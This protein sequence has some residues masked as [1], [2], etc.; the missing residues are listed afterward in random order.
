VYESQKETI[1]LYK[2]KLKGLLGAEQ[3]IKPRKTGGPTLS[4][5]EG[6]SLIKQKRGRGRPRKY[7]DVIYYKNPSELCEKL[8]EKLSAKQA[9][10]TGLD[11]IITS[12]LDEL[13]N[14]KYINKD[15][16][17]RLFRKIFH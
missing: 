17:D 13:L 5:G 4:T 6:L 12:I 1:K 2:E 16:Y 9:G 3:F 7:L 8:N 10:N 11:N 15:E 14:I